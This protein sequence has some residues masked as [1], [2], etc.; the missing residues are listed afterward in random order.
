MLSGL[1]GQNIVSWPDREVKKDFKFGLGKRE[2]ILHNP[3]A[4]Y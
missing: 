4:L 3:I 1:F 2:G